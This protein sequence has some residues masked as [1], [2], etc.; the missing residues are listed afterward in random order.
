MDS[1]IT[2]VL[3]ERRCISK[4]DWWSF[5]H[6]FSPSA[7]SFFF[8]RSASATRL[9]SFFL[10]CFI[11]LSGRE[12]EKTATTKT[13][14]IAD[15]ALLFTLLLHKFC[16]RCVWSHKCLKEVEYFLHAGT[17]C[18]NFMTQTIL[19]GDFYQTDSS[20]E[21]NPKYRVDNSV[22]QSFCVSTC[23]CSC[24]DISICVYLIDQCTREEQ[25]CVFL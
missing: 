11:I 22:P 14:T 19:V 8:W 23:E 6:Y 25:L 2:N 5:Y 7:S 15:V 3:C 16:C 13:T 12:G 24:V 18:I 10:S 9:I 20:F 17:F 4:S 21:T 1:K